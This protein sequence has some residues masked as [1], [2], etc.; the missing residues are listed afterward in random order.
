MENVRPAMNSSSNPNIRK[1]QRLDSAASILARP[2]KTP[3]RSKKQDSDVQRTTPS[4]SSP[5]IRS[6]KID[7]SFTSSQSSKTLDKCEDESRGSTSGVGQA[8]NI[9]TTSAVQN[10]DK[11]AA[12]EAVVRRLRQEIRAVR[13]DIDVLERAEALRGSTTNEK[14]EALISKWRLAS[15]AAADEL[16][17]TIKARIDAQGGMSALQRSAEIHRQAHNGQ[18]P[19][20]TSPDDQDSLNDS[21]SP[22]QDRDAEERSNEET[23]VSIVDSDVFQLLTVTVFHDGRNARSDA[24]RS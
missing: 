22:T 19:D 11:T 24:H 12:S 15:Q 23:N 3:L 1:R 2:F 10:C 21:R 20:E 17:P 14:L 5:V 6:D 4:S 7:L 16:F 8:D 13:S 9:T 18:E